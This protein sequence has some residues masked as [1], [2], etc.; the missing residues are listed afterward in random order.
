MYYELISAEGG[1]PVVVDEYVRGR[2]SQALRPYVVSYSG[3]RQRGVPPMRHLGLPSPSLTMILT[4]DD[5]LVVE[6]HPDPRQGAGRYDALIGGLHLTPAVIT[7]DGRQA[8]LQVALSPSGCRALLGL[9]AG[10]LGGLDVDAAALL[11]DRAVAEIRERLAHA[12]DWP[13]R[14]AQLDT[15]LNKRINPDKARPEI[16]H[17]WERIVRN[18]PVGRVA[19]E[20]G[21]SNRHLTTRFRAETGLNPK[22]AARVARFDRA[23][24]SLSPHRRIAEVAAAHGYAD[25]SH[26]V[27]EFRALAGCT[28]SEWLA[29]EFA[30]VQALQLQPAHDDSHD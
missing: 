25:Q 18:V 5:P 9:P 11:G 28:P 3:Y 21:W 23:R 24:R 4:L 7:H 8:G 16:T 29:D 12:A 15:W 20:V 14:L 30:F 26:L 17:A 2:P 13:S 10:E 22:E 1:E 6:S 19:E 27:R